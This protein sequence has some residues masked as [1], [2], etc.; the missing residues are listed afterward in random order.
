MEGL[1]AVGSISAHFGLAAASNG[2]Q[3]VPTFYGYGVLAKQGPD[4]ME[5]KS[6]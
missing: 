6:I 5:M 2:G 4:W 1:D 3:P